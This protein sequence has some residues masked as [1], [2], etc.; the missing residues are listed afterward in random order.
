MQDEDQPPEDIWLDSEAVAAHFE[1][2]RE[3]YASKSDAPASE[4]IPEATE[5][6]EN[7]LLKGLRR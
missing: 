4:S 2:V 3:R 5:M 7:E 6:H 1:T